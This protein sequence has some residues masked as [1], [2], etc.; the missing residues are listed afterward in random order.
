MD[1]SH[2]A[3]NCGKSECLGNFLEGGKAM[4]AGGIMKYSFVFI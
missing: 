4:M 1:P 2:A 3:A